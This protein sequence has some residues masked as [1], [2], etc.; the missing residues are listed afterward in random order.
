[1]YLIHRETYTKIPCTISS[2]SKKS[3]KKELKKGSFSFDWKEIEGEIYGL[4]I[5]D[6]NQLVGLMSLI[7]QFEEYRIEIKLLEVSK[8]NK[9]KDKRYE[10][11]AGSLIAYAC[12]ISFNK[13]YF[14]FVSL[15]PKTRLIDH[16]IEN[17]GFV[18]FG[19]Q[20]GSDSE[21][22]KKLISKFIKYER[23][24]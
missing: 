19:R 13:N 7:D 15:L 9:G 11:I 3:L 6:F 21:N 1:M 10:R 17:Y 16:Y 5:D 4:Y 8:E 24:K 20:L 22:S 14:G 23:F 12:N 18:Q 2:V